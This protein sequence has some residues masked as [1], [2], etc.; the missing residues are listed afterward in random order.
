M[1]NWLERCQS[2]I[3]ESSFLIF[4]KWIKKCVD[5]RGA[6]S[7]HTVLFRVKSKQSLH[8]LKGKK[9][10]RIYNSVLVLLWLECMI[11]NK[12]VLF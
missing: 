8:R 9:T 4:A 3:L 5:W 1:C 7:V 11:K 10:Y 6:V 12:I 2:N